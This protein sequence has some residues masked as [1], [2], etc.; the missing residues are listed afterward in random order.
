MRNLLACIGGCVV[1][2]AGLIVLGALVGLGAYRHT[3]PQIAP[4]EQTAAAFAGAI[5]AGDD[6]LALRMI[7]GAP[8]GRDGD[9]YRAHAAEARRALGAFRVPPGSRIASRSLTVLN[10]T[11]TFTAGMEVRGARA[12]G[13]ITVTLEK[14]QRDG[15]WLVRRWTWRRAGGGERG[16]PRDL[17]RTRGVTAG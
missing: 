1:L 6:A 17:V 3:A 5:G 16:E 15:Q 13:V 11:W 4:A 14:R 9:A 12:S 8:T 10:G 7:Y 2:V